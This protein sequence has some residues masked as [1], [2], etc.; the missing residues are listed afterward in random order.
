MI[1]GF[2]G[3]DPGQGNPL[4]AALPPMLTLDLRRGLSSWIE[5]TLRFAAEQIAE[6]RPGSETV[7]A[8]LS[9]LIFVEA[10]RT[11][12]DSMPPGHTGWLAGLRDPFVGR[13]L[14]LLHGRVAEAWSL[15]TLGREVGLSRSALAERF[16][17]LLGEPPM[18]YL[19]RWRMQVAARHL[20]ATGITVGRVAELVGYDSEPAFNRA[21]KRTFGQP[22]AAWRAGCMN[23]V[24]GPPQ[25]VAGVEQFA[26]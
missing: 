13:C 11:Y 12:L 25:R 18:H 20:A 1:C 22:P 15:E 4:I 17:R 9:E 10:V 21:F 24:G 16:V 8:R 5:S 19:A 23:G 7:I 6:G 26:S 3:Y 2:L 14:A